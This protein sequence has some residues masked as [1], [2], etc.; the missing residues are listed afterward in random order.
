MRSVVGL[1]ATKGTYGR[2][3][4]RGDAIAYGISH[5]K[6]GDIVVIAGKG[7]ENISGNLRAEVSDG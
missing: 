3:P 1:D 7:H 5:A 6:P 2:I 4:D